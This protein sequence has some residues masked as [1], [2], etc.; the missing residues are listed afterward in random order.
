MRS[1]I[2]LFCLLFSLSLF[3]QNFEL[4]RENPTV[5]INKTALNFPW[6]GGLNNPQPQMI[7]LD[8][9]GS[10]E[11]YIFDKQGHKNLAFERSSNG[12]F[13]YAP[14]LVEFFPENLIHW[15]VARDFD[16]DGNVDL[17]AHS[18]TLVSGIL[19]YKGVRRSDGRLEFE[20]LTWGD[21]L[22]LLYFPLSN[23]S[24]TQIFVS[25][26]DYP[27]INDVDCDGDM[28]ILTFNL[29]GGYVEFFQNQ[30][31]ER[32]YGNDSLIFTL[33]DNCYGGIYES[34]LSPEVT[35]ATSADGCA[36]PFHDPNT[37][38]S[39]RH[40][41]STLLTLDNNQDGLPELLLG[42][43]SFTEIVLLKN[44]GTCD[45]AYF[46]DQ[47]LDYP[48]TDVPVDIVFF[49][50]AF[51]TDI[52]QDG[53]KDFI[54][55]PNQL[56]NAEDKNVFW[57]YKNQ[58]Q[59]DLPNPVLVDSQYIVRDMIDVGTGSIPTAFDVNDDGLMD[60]VIGNRTIFTGTVN[61]NNSSLQVFLNVGT[62]TA[63]VFELTNTDYLDMVQFL[64]TTSAFSPA[65][66]DL[67]GD[68]RPDAIVGGKSGQLFY[69][70]NN[71][72]SGP[73]TF[74]NA[75]YNWMGIDVGQSARPVIVD[76]NRD[77][78]NDL[79][80]GSRSGRISYYQNQGTATNPM[81]V[82]D[83]EA[84]PNQIQLGGIDTRDLGSS[85]GYASPAVIERDG[86]YLL[87]TGTNR[88]QIEVYG[89]IENNI[90]GTFELLDYSIGDYLPGFRSEPAL[91]NFIDNGTFEIVIGNGRGGLDF[92]VTDIP[93]DNDPLGVETV[94]KPI[95]LSIFP[96]PAN[97]TLNVRTTSSTAGVLKLYS[98]QGQLLLAQSLNQRQASIDLTKIPS[99]IYILQYNN[100]AEKITKR[101][102]VGH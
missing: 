15:V 19:V 81:F 76:L 2:L 52:D 58:G 72:A 50:A 47:I 56:A 68:G 33:A 100:G 6:A 18:D 45:D 93:D 73:H 77:G 37:T 83:P 3:G 71:S 10:T 44:A 34:G 48:Q 96:N 92:F 41:G 91:A 51:Y 28:D 70:P 84:A 90:D 21:P 24:R 38:A 53:V 16:G 12:E 8:G 25:T 95:E 13:S 32:G 5:S 89:N 85:L 98:I 20:R 69:L 9:D 82:S 94:E 80:I 62:A 29:G 31:Q 30:S 102:V 26:I 14:E 17:F 49:P 66:G 43:I 74:G 60:L 22:P 65:F 63:P 54:A 64:N 61:L 27:E 75:I 35:L 23:G 57:Y 87:L 40:A 39:A 88:G 4:T 46:N 86:E 67:N 78:L 7:D 1:T 59:N 97:T 11:L 101:L 42:D 55:A 79:V 99:G 36:T